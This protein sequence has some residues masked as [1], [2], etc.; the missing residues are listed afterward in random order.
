MGRRTLTLRT[1]RLAELTPDDLAVVVGAEASGPQCATNAACAASRMV[2]S[3]CGCLT[4]YC[5]IDVC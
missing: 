1:E 2:I 5:S 4:G 3:L